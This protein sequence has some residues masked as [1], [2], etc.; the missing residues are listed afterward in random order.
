[1]SQYSESAQ[2]AIEKAAQERLKGSN[3]T[4]VDSSGRT[5]LDPTFNERMVLSGFWNKDVSDEM[6]AV[7]DQLKVLQEGQK[8]EQFVKNNVDEYSDLQGYDV[9]KGLQ[10]AKDIVKNEDKLRAGTQRLEDLGLSIETLNS[11]IKDSGLEVLDADTRYTSAQLAPYITQYNTNLRA[12]E[13]APELQLLNDKLDEQRQARIASDQATQKAQT[14]LQDYR[15]YQIEY[16]KWAEEQN[17]ARR[18]HELQVSQTDKAATRNQTYDLAVMQMENN[19]ADRMY[20]R[21]ADERQARRDERKDRQLMILQL[22]KGMQQM[23][24]A[25]AI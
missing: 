8:V 15:K 10:G 17:T 24:N 14:D 11:G 4:K 3:P 16:Q 18:A 12:E 7:Q 25:F 20:R 1:M 23:G 6:S 9:T 19:N 13:R 21:E 5:V 22:I 2:K